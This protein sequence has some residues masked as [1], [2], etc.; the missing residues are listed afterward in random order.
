MLPHAIGGNVDAQ[1]LNDNFSYLNT[2]L[3][4]TE[5]IRQF[6]DNSL[7]AASDVSQVTE[8]N[9]HYPTLLHTPTYDGLGEVVHPDVIYIEGGFGAKKWRYWMAN[10]PM[11]NRDERYENPSVIVSHDGITW[12]T[13]DGLINPIVPAPVNTNDHNSDTDMVFYANQLWLYYRETMRSAE[14]REQRIKLTKSS[15]GVNWSTPV[16]VL[17]NNQG[18]SDALLS[19]TVIHKDGLFQMWLID[20]YD[21]L[22]KTTSPN[23]T[24]WGPLEPCETIGMPSDRGHWHIDVTI[25]EGRLDMLANTSSGSSGVDGRLHYAYSE[26][27]G[28][29]WNIQAPFIERIYDFEQGRHYRGTIRPVKGNPSLYE[30]WYSS[31]SGENRYRVAYLNAV[32][33]NNVLYPLTPSDRKWISFDGLSAPTV[34]AG[35]VSTQKLV[36]GGEDATSRLK[37]SRLI[38]A[39]LANGWTNN[40]NMTT[41]YYREG[42]R[43]YLMGRILPGTT[44][45]GT[46]IFTLETGFR[47]LQDSMFRQRFA[48]VYIQTDGTVTI[49]SYNG[50]YVALDGIHFFAS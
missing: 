35:S 6:K 22:V 29:T 36:V 16:E 26:D 25:N 17:L 13:P 18:I 24:S 30:I 37:R 31:L 49:Y 21:N 46:R 2:Q 19:P 8:V 28:L 3:I 41:R 48:D 23:G 4:Q 43:V 44:A 27:D 5:A 50:T 1:E 45:D 9:R 40:A 39:A 38:N 47:P 7:L 34:A 12:E 10:T 15:D 14:P 11:P 32:R 42:D 20:G 33:I